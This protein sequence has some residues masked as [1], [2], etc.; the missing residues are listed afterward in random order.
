MNCVIYARVSS[1]EQEKEGF[2]IP[3]QRKLLREYARKS[4][5]QIKKEFTDVETAKTAGR[6]SFGDMLEYLKSEFS[7]RVILVEKTDRLYRNFKDYVLLEELDREIQSSCQELC[8][9][10]FQAAAFSV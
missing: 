5:L 8:K 4:G 3:A 7:V 10:V 6:S 9:L 2:S 1:K